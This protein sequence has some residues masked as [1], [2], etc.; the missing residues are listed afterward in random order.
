MR[1][2]YF[3]WENA[4]ADNCVHFQ[5]TFQPR[6]FPELLSKP[7][8]DNP[9]I[10]NISRHW[11]G[12]DQ[13]IEHAFSYHSSF[14]SDPAVPGHHRHS[15]GERVKCHKNAAQH[16]YHHC[17][18]TFVPALCPTFYQLSQSPQ[19]SIGKIPD[20]PECKNFASEFAEKNLHPPTCTKGAAASESLHERIS[21]LFA[22]K[23]GQNCSPAG[24]FC[25]IC[26]F[27]SFCVFC[28]FCEICVSVSFCLLR[29][30]CN[31]C[32]SNSVLCDFCKFCVICVCL[33]HSVYSAN[34]V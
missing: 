31:M 8:N 20:G 24:R 3:W 1:D 25:V 22:Q 19:I 21:D 27:V 16:L 29:I 23:L 30:L 10:L 26:A 18:Q 33:S 17:A 6:F 28:I 32:V 13:N 4:T 9:T 12:K 7:F 15:H 11:Q 34:S 2:D 14:S 5:N